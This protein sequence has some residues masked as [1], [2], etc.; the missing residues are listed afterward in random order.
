M[1]ENWKHMTDKL[2]LPICM[3]VR[4]TCLCVVWSWTVSYC[5]R[6][7]CMHGAKVKMWPISILR[8][9][10]DYSSPSWRN[11]SL[12][13]TRSVQPTFSVL[14]QHHIT[15]FSVIPDLLSEL[16]KFQHHTQ[17]CA[18]CGISVVSSLYLRP[19]RWW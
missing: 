2:D 1:K 13:L 3:C 9:Y 6:Y 14:L 19:I 4:C 16:S 12:L 8:V 10:S 18:E 5:V 11:S 15:N 17:I 7:V